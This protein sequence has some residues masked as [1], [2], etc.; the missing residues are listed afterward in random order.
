MPKKRT[1]DQVQSLWPKGKPR[2][3]FTAHCTITAPTTK[4]AATA[5]QQLYEGAFAVAGSF[6]VD[7]KEGT[8]KG[9]KT[10]FEVTLFRDVPD[11]ADVVDAKLRNGADFHRTLQRQLEAEIADAREHYRL[12]VTVKIVSG[13]NFLR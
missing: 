2:Y 5:L 11:D 7:S 4:S 3:C 13:P 8:R 9:T 1:S 6:R 12:P 10:V